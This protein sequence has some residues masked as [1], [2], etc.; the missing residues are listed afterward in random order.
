MEGVT[1]R[2]LQIHGQVQGVG[3]RAAMQREADRLQLSGWVRNRSDGSVEA[4]VCG[5]AAQVEQIIAWAR[6]GPLYAAVMQ[7][8]VSEAEAPAGGS[9][10]IRLPDT[11]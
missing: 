9:F 11:W 3:Y 8:V 2:L 1:A 6:H 4:L 7:V 10:E 5:P